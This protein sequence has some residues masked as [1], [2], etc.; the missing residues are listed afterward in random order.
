MSDADDALWNYEVRTIKFVWP[1]T[2]THASDSITLKCIAREYIVIT[3]ALHKYTGLI[4]R[5]I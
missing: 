1:A 2:I 3:A 4:A 5:E